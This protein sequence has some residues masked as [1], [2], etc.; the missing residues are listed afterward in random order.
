MHRPAWTLAVLVLAPLLVGGL[1]ARAPRA[2]TALRLGVRELTLRADLLVEGRVVATRAV[3]RGG[4]IETEVELAVDRTFVG[5]DAGRRT[6]RVPGGVLPDGRGMV[7]AGFAPPR[8]G[9]EVLWFLAEESPVGTRLPV[10]LAQGQLRLVTDRAGNKVATRSLGRLTLADG[11][12]GA[13]QHAGV[14]A[15][16]DY[17]ELRAEIE[18][19][20]ALR[21]G[22]GA[23][24][25]RK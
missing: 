4:R 7:I 16:I 9:E 17:A 22:F 13:L 11:A 15:V 2:S 14:G 3:E 1:R 10:G 8:P 23:G 21:R 12:G 20:L 25:E 6:V 18:S 19:A 24:S 5:E